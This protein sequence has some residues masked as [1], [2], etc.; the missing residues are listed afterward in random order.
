VALM[1]MLFGLLFC[2]LGVVST[3][4]GLIYDEV[5]ARPNFVVRH[6]SGFSPTLPVDSAPGVGG[7]HGHVAEDASNGHVTAEELPST[8]LGSS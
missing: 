2:L 1:V 4:I 7:Q 8:S 3:Y 6:T 5:K